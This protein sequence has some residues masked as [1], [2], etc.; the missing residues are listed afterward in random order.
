MLCLSEL[1]EA[2]IVGILSEAPTAYEQ[3]VLADESLAG[4]ANAAGRVRRE[5][6][7]IIHMETNKHHDTLALLYGS[8]MDT[9]RRPQQE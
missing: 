2:D 9:E 4:S 1:A 6:E 3:G 5:G 7:V 8:G